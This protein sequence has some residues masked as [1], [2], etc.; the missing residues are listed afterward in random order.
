MKLRIKRIIKAEPT[1]RQI[2]GITVIKGNNTTQES[3]I[4]CDSY[5]V[6]EWLKLEPLNN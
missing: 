3:I 1:I 6:V 5:E 4:E 2:E